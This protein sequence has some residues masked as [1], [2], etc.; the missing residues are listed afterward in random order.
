MNDNNQKSDRTE[1]LRE[2]TEELTEEEKRRAYMPHFYISLGCF[3]VGCIL[4]ILSIIFTFV[5]KNGIAVFFLIGSMIAE[6]ASI[7]FLNA[8]KQR[9]GEGKLRTVFVILS[10]VIMGA[11]MIIFIAGTTTAG[12]ASN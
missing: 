8:M 12:I 7:S 10:Y 5:L 2:E 9:G 1:E 6:L 11:A 3:A 4:F